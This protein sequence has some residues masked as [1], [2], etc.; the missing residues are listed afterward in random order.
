MG[1]WRAVSAYRGENVRLSE[2][3][4]A[5]C[6][7]LVDFL[8]NDYHSDHGKLRMTTARDYIYLFS[9][10]LNLAVEKGY[11]TRNPLFFVKIHDRIT[12]ERPRKQYLFVEEVKL[13][14][15]TQCPVIS[16]PQVKQ[17]FLFS[18]YCGLRTSDIRAL[19]WGQIHKDGD[20]WRVAVVMKKTDTPIY[21][22]LSKQAMK[23]LPE[24]G[25]AGDDDKVFSLPTTSPKTTR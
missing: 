24:R 6:D 17:A 11:I 1:M 7:G 22:P 2:V 12:R 18:C 25:D 4:I 9:A 15:D 21:L 19:R 23:W 16:R 10:V 20:Q 8:R 5:Y 14:M 13:L 3:D